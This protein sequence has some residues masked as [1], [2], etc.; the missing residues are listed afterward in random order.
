M[1]TPPIKVYGYRWVMLL[2]F[3]FINLTMQLLWICFAPVAIR[4]AQF[5]HVTDFEINFLAMI[6][7]FIYIPIAIPAAW[8]IDTFGFRKA[9]GFGAILLGTFGLLR[10]LFT[11]DFTLTVIFTIGLAIA[12]PFLL[13]AFTKLAALWFPLKDR[14]TIIGLIFLSTFMG[15]GL[16]EL[17]TPALVLQFGL[18]G[19]QLIYGLVTAISAIIFLIVVREKPP[20]P[21]SPASQL[22]RALMLDGLKQILRLRVFWYL[23]IVLFVGNSIFNGLTAQVE[24]IVRPRGLSISEAGDLGAAML[25]GGVIGAIAMPALSDRLRKRKGLMVVGFALAIP[26]MIGVAFGA[27]YILLLASFFWLGLFTTGIA[28]VTYQ[29]GAEVTYP[30]PEGT[31]NGL[32]ALAGQFSVVFIFAMGWSNDALGSFLPSMIVLIGLMFIGTILLALLKE[33]PMMK[34]QSAT[35]PSTPQEIIP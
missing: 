33:S 2:A 29:Y 27:S 21:A 13:N 30:V 19:M 26:G 28:P 7:M 17:L 8:A 24:T 23:A 35:A 9:V 10:G 16:G 34:A 18:S 14:A 11:T 15:I 32:F 31:S 5:Y 22:E 6:F 20:T 4:A 12:Q 25:L 1:E 3:M